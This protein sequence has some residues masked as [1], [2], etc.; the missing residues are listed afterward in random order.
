MQEKRKSAPWILAVIHFLK[1]MFLMPL[2]FLVVLFLP[3]MF[4][5]RALGG[6]DSTY[7]VEISLIMIFAIWVGVL[8]S[9]GGMMNKYIITESDNILRISLIIAVVIFA[10]DRISALAGADGFNQVNIIYTVATVI[11]L[12][13]F[14]LFSKKYIHNNS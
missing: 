9:A 5:N 13:V 2:A 4:L 3:L 8:W 7:A 10:L 14:Y 11:M 12:V 6:N 1:S